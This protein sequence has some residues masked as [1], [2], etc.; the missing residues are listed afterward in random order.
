MWLDVVRVGSR[1]KSQKLEG[2]NLSLKKRNLTGGQSLKSDIGSIYETKDLFQ[3]KQLLIKIDSRNIPTAYISLY[4]F[5]RLSD[6]SL[7][8]ILVLAKDLNK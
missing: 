8:L 3:V 5:I 7:G 2:C 1:S 4:L 6:Q